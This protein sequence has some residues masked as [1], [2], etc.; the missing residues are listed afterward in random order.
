MIAQVRLLDEAVAEV[1]GASVWYEEQ[2]AGLGL[3]FLA[4]VDRTIDHLSRWPLTGTPIEGVDESLLVRR[5]IVG[6]FP[7]YLAYLSTQPSFSGSPSG[8]HVTVAGGV[9]GWSAKARA[10]AL[11]VSTVT[12]ASG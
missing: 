7:Y 12:A 4:A 8:I 6:S 9:D 10:A 3:A 11:A 5:M 1:E 2:S